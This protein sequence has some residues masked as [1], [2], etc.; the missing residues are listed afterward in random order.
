[1]HANNMKYVHV[2]VFLFNITKNH[3]TIGGKKQGR[4]TRQLT[5]EEMNEQ[6]KGRYRKFHGALQGGR[7]RVAGRMRR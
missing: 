3:P 6:I 5:V 2:V 4:P 7:G 1:M